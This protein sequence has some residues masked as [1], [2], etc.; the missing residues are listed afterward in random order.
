MSHARR[1]LWFNDDRPDDVVDDAWKQGASRRKSRPGAC[2]F[3]RRFHDRLKETL[4]GWTPHLSELERRRQVSSGRARHLGC[5]AEPR[6]G[7]SAGFGRTGLSI[8][9]A[10]DDA[11]HG[12]RSM[13]GQI[14]QEHRSRE[15]QLVQIRVWHMALTHE[16]DELEA[17]IHA[18]VRPI[19]ADGRTNHAYTHQDS[20]V[21]VSGWQRTAALIAQPGL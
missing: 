20:C 16:I 3:L 19:E 2:A 18:G 17:A 11:W 15:K 1:S 21:G 9:D 12:S 6:L 10:V 5:C 8:R 4:D 7:R 14:E 13:R